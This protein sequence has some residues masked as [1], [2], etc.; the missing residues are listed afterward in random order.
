[1]REETAL[2]SARGAG[3][4]HQKNPAPETWGSRCLAGGW[5]WWMEAGCWVVMMICG[6]PVALLVGGFHQADKIY[7]LGTVLKACLALG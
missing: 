4:C 2:G 1:M 5:L 3:M 7:V 6:F